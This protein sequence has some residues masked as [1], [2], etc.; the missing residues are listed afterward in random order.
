MVV[1]A[2]QNRAA[3]A[4]A[5]GRVQRLRTVVVQIEWPDV[6]RATRQ[7]EAGGGRGFD[8]TCAL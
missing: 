8:P 6:Q 7:I 3:C 2:C 1:L 4:E 5:D